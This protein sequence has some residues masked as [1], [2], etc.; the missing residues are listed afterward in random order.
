M[1]N[2]AFTL[3]EIIVVIAIIALLLT[4]VVPSAGHARARARDVLCRNNLK[5]IRTAFA[6]S[7]GKRTTD[8][9]AAR[10]QYYP[11]GYEWPL[12]TYTT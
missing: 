4:I 11:M 7:A 10:V 1:R 2:R 3:M 12:V 9:R 5:E 6:T 8:N